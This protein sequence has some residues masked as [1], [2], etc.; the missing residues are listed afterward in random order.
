MSLFVIPNRVI[1][2]LEKIQK[3]F[4]WGEVGFGIKATF[5]ELVYCLLGE[6]KKGLR[7]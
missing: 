4:L 7:Y 3:D 5:D 1:V 2:N 6:T